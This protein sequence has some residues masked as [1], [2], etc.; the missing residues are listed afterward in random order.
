MHGAWLSLRSPNV[1][2]GVAVARA[3]PP[4]G[5]P[6]CLA[7]ACRRRFARAVPHRPAWCPHVSQGTRERPTAEFRASKRARVDA[8]HEP[9]APKAHKYHSAGRAV[10]KAEAFAELPLDDSREILE[11]GEGKQLPNVSGFNFPIPG[12]ARQG[13]KWG[14]LTKEQAQ[15]IRATAEVEYIAAV[16]QFTN[17]HVFVLLKFVG[18]ALDFTPVPLRYRFRMP[19]D[20]HAWPAPVKA[21]CARAVRVGDGQQELWHLILQSHSH[22]APHDISPFEPDAG[23]PAEQVLPAASPTLA[24]PAG[25]LP[26]PAPSG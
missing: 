2:N 23:A 13:K 26:S 19:K 8:E 7:N 10:T 9:E 16:W 25:A 20:P 6:C 15:E 1:V 4:R 12:D 17:K 14:K 5:C 22:P 24:S 3:R 11:G 21:L 18:Y